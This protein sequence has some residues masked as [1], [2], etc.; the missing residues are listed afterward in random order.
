VGFAEGVAAGDEG[1]G[2][3]VVHRHAGEGFA[4]IFGRFEGARGCRS[5]LRD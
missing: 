5:A 3:F 2:L 4:D 1:D